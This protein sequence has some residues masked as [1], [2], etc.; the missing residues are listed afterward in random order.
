[1]VQMALGNKE[2]AEDEEKE[3]DEVTM[4]IFG[5]IANSIDPAIQVEI[6]FP[7]KKAD[8]MMPILDM[9]MAMPDQKPMWKQLGQVQVLQEATIKQIHH[10]GEVGPI[11]QNQEI[12]TDGYGDDKTSLLLTQPG[13]ERGGGGDGR[14]RQDD[15]E[16]WVQWEVSPWDH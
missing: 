3:A 6:D 2:E 10:D 7:S 1:M 8:K 4:R 16:V 11:E 12:N 5:E 13:E 9:Q 15:E 14:L